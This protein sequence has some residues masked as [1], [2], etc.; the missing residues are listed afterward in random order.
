MYCGTA[1]AE[2]VFAILVAQLVFG[3][4]KYLDGLY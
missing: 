3:A 1:Y 2:V 4:C